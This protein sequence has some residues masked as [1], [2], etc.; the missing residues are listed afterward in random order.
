M[1]PGAYPTVRAIVMCYNGPYE[2]SGRM[3]H[4]DISTGSVLGASLDFYDSNGLVA[5]DTLSFTFG[6]PTAFDDTTGWYRMRIMVHDTE[7]IYPN[8]FFYNDTTHDV[9]LSSAPSGE[10]PAAASLPRVFSLGQNQPNPFNPSTSISYSIPEGHE[11]VEV[12]LQ[13]VRPSRSPCKAS[14][15]I[16]AS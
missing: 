7:Y 5:Y 2:V 6:Y 4:M 16:L 10:S 1:S 13:R 3:E 14:G 15:I 11:A 8:S 12:N 9:V